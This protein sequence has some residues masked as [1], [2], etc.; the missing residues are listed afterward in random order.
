MKT[1][2]SAAVV[3][4][5]VV[6]GP[7]QAGLDIELLSQD[8][9]WYDA[10]GSHTP[11]NINYVVGDA[12]GTNFHN[13]SVFDLSSI[14]DSIVSARLLLFNGA[15]PPNTEDGYISPD[16]FETYALFD[17]TT[18]IGVLT[19][20]TGSVGAYADLGGGTS[21]GSV[22]ISSAD[23]GTFVVVEL[24]AASIAA[25]NSAR[26]KFAFGGAIT[27]IGHPIDVQESAFWFSHQSPDVRLIVTIPAPG[28]L[29]LLA[30][31]GLGAIRRRRRC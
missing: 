29:A 13:F 25:L 8:T 27:T 1:I 5:L 17:V 10:A 28:S 21:F 22:D 18:D 4:S 26:G 6:C 3:L 30:T 14:T 2:S 19:G 15:S 7:V 12:L 9:G 24:N 31:F 11:S 16:P 20:G 23:N